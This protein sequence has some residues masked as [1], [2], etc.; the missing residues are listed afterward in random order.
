MKQAE[1]VKVAE[2]INNKLGQIPKINTNGN[3][4]ELI[5]RLSELNNFVLIEQYLSNEAIE[6]IRGLKG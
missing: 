5:K 1:L 2:E 6:I 3:R 4:E